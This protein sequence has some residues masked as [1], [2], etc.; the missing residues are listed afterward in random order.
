MSGLRTYLSQNAPWLATGG[1]LMFLSSFG[2]TF[3]I[4]IFGGEIRSQ[5]DLTLGE[6]GGIY[7]LGTS[8]SALVMIWAGGLT[9]YYRVR[10]LGPV[11]LA[12]LSLACVAMAFN[13]S[14]IGLT[15]I[16]FALRLFGQGMSTHVSAVAM[17]RWFDAT[18]GRALSIA[19]LGYSLGE[20]TLPLTFVALKS[21]MDWHGLWLASALVAALSIPVLIRLLRTERT[22]QA[23]AESAV[24][25]GMDGR[26][27][28]RKQALTHPLFWL[29]TP[30]LLGPA[31]FGTAI[32]FHQVHLAEIKGWSHIEFVGL[33]P[34]FTVSSIGFML[35]SGWALDRWGSLRLMPFYQIPAIVAFVVFAVAATPGQMLAGLVAYAVIT[36]S[37]ATLP[38]AF[39][40]DVYGTAHLGAIKSM[41]AAIMVL[42]SAIGPGLTGWLIDLGIG[43]ERQFFG[44]AAY[45]CF[46]C[47]L[48]RVAI[49]KARPHMRQGA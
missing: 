25:L 26:H 33:L 1:L 27:W 49:R 28:T 21:K 12:G 3:F 39:W 13:T 45:F 11:V 32:L 48:V 23:H 46:A 24:S 18:R 34:F 2:Q 43:L 7:S 22:P 5:F 19:G 40:A 9:D 36:G 14:V 35:L 31:A 42:G 6:W 4:S 17:T 8:V 37:M 10:V 15:A 30:S 47:L 41:A 38:N 20:A 16:I 29:M 44:V